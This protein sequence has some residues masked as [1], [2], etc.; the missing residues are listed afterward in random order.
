M[1]SGLIDDVRIYKR[2]LS[3]EEIETVMGGGSLS[4]VYFPPV[5][6]ANLYNKEEQGNRSVNSK[7]YAVMAD[8]WLLE[9]LF[10]PE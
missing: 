3:D 4:V 5:S 10:P 2:A 6:I 9:L 8:E 7:D 1:F